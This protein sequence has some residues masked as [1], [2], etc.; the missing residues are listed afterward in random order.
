MSYWTA[1]GRKSAQVTYAKIKRIL[2]KE[3]NV[4]ER[5]L[6]S[7]YAD[8]D[9][10]LCRHLIQYFMIKYSGQT[11][12]KIA[13]RMNRHYSSVIHARKSMRNRMQ[14]EPNFKALVEKIEGKI[15]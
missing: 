9:V 11:L 7:F 13:K 1:P 5:E 15:V 3:I 2:L 14:T 6:N 8:D 10:N 4:T 12:E